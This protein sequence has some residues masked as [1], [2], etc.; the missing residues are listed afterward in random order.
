MFVAIDDATSDDLREAGGN[1]D[2]SGFVVRR[3]PNVLTQELS[4]KTAAP[5]VLLG[6]LSPFW[7]NY[8]RSLVQILVVAIIGLSPWHRMVSPADLSNDFLVFW[9]VGHLAMTANAVR[10]YDPVWFSAWQSS[11]L[12]S[13]VPKYLQFFYPP[14]TLLLTLI[15]GPFG[16]MGGYLIWTIALTGSGIILLRRAQIPWIIII[17]GVLSTA[18]LYNMLAAQLGFLTGAMFIAALALLDTASSTSGAIFGTL[19][20]KPQAGLLA[21]IVLLARHRYRPIMTGALALAGLCAA[22]TLICGWAVWPAFLHDGLKTS[23][24]ILVAPFPTLYEQKGAS[25]FWMVRSFG[26]TVASAWIMQAISALAA[27][28]LCFRAWRRPATDRTA[29]IALTV[30]LTLLVTPYGYTTDMAGFSIMVAWLAW[31]RQRLDIADVLMWLWPALCPLVAI[32]FHMELSPL[33]LALSAARA[34]K[35]LDGIGTTAAACYPATV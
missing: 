11:H 15:T 27:I 20:L 26:G 5:W 25:V 1:G 33:V 2:M 9:P 22:T 24:K 21:P 13:H 34:W 4:L 30:T 16:F 8:A 18:G 29:L 35:R 23:H 12:I 3:L 17:V 19:I 32:E 31:E 10:I 14:P 6:A 7:L 28:I